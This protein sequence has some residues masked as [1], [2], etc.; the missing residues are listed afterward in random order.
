MG[1]SHGQGEEGRAEG[2]LFARRRDCHGARARR[3]A[4]ASGRSA[5]LLPERSTGR[6]EG[7]PE[8]RGAACLVGSALERSAGAG[9]LYRRWTRGVPPR[10]SLRLRRS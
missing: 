1:I 5:L 6:P 10:A 4:G 9:G 2:D 3:A 7:A 8:A